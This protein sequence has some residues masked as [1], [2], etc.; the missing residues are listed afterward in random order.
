MITCPTYRGTPPPDTDILYRG[1]GPPLIVKHFPLPIHAAPS[2]DALGALASHLAQD[3]SPGD[4]YCLYGQVGAGKSAFSRAFIRAAAGDPDLPVPSPTY[5][6]VNEYDDHGDPPVQHYDLYRLGNERDLL[7]LDLTRMTKGAVCLFEWAE[8][9][10]SQRPS[11]HLAVH[12]SIVEG[13]GGLRGELPNHARSEENTSASCGEDEAEDAYTD[14]RSRRVV[15]VPHGMRWES[16]ITGI[17]NAFN[18]DQGLGREEGLKLI[19]TAAE[20]PPGI[21]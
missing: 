7:R 2:E 12:I 11:E 1:T 8:R 13:S 4:C 6:L 19:S 21:A 15:L 5:L 9:L 10:Q 14:R 17:V 18:S 3:L 16:C 20:P